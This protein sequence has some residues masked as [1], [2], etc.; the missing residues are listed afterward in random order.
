LRPLEHLFT[1]RHDVEI[2]RGVKPGEFADDVIPGNG[3]LGLRWRRGRG[4]Q[5]HGSRQQ[6][7][8]A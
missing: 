4:E 7:K 6:P 8:V 2:R 5:E 3:A 1:Q